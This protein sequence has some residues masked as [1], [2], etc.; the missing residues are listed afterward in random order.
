MV[1]VQ[2]IIAEE[3]KREERGIN[4]RENKSEKHPLKNNSKKKGGRNRKEIN[5]KANEIEEK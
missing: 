3:K 1:G 4:E 2:K 5:K